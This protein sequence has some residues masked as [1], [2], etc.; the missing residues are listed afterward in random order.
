MRRV[1]K[2]AR[3]KQK[4]ARILAAA[5]SLMIREGGSALTTN[6]IAAEAGVGVGSL[7]EYFPD[8]QSIINQLIEDLATS[9]S[10]HLLA[11]LALLGDADPGQLID[12]TVSL[13]FDLYL[14]HHAL[15]R[16]LWALSTE[17]RI[18]GHRPGE[19][20]IMAGVMDRL[21]SHQQD[22]G[23]VDLK[24]TCFTIFHMVESL[25]SRM[26]EQG[27]T[28]WNPATCK[29]EISRVVRR[30]LTLPEPG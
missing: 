29:N 14:D 2:Q 9:E 21:A 22:L 24:L 25:A 4:V 19:T 20:Q 18:V 5:R 16:A 17:P 6:R 30:Y 26:V 1:P 27:L 11:R 3:S 23:I 8:K 10:E 7:Y 28:D 13:V 15:Y 12:E